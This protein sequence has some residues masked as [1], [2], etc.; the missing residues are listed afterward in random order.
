MHLDEIWTT[1]ELGRIGF[2]G[3]RDNQTMKTNPL[4]I[5]LTVFPSKDSAEVWETIL[6]A[7]FNQIELEGDGKSATITI[8]LET[9]LRDPKGLLKSLANQIATAYWDYCWHAQDQLEVETS[10]QDPLEETEEHTITYLGN[11]G[12]TM[13]FY[14]I[15]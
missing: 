14:V 10:G 7:L 9:P 5:W 4:T 13:G 11:H 3:F 8:H 12:D 1:V 6:K 2:I 15:E